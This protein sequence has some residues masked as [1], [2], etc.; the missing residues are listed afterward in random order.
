MAR[1]S[2]RRRLVHVPFTLLQS[3]RFHRWTWSCRCIGHL[4]HDP[5]LSLHNNNQFRCQCRPSILC[6]Q[7]SALRPP[8][9]ADVTLLAKGFGNTIQYVVQHCRGYLSIEARLGSQALEVGRCHIATKR[10]TETQH[11]K[12]P[13]QY[14]KTRYRERIVMQLYLLHHYSTFLDL[15]VGY[16]IHWLVSSRN[17][18]IRRFRSWRDGPRVAS[19]PI[20]HKWL[21]WVCISYLQD[22][23]NFTKLQYFIVSDS[24]E[25]LG[26]GRRRLQSLSWKDLEWLISNSK[27]KWQNESNSRYVWDLRST[28][29]KCI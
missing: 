25:E 17:L 9:S 28:V 27:I 20:I 5:E 19:D 1:D 23:A 2:G 11:N 3:R 21:R 14:A 16:V 18:S 6:L 8:A 24:T 13:I 15:A 29:K 26:T 10:P 12:K 7:G 22:F 4:G